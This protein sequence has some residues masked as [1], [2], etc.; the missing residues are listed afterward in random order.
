MDLIGFAEPDASAPAGTAE[1]APA[2]EATAPAIVPSVPA[3]T[4][5]P[6]EGMSGQGAPEASQLRIWE[7]NHERELAQFATKEESDR[8]EKREAAG[9]QLRQWHEDRAEEIKKRHS[10]KRAEEE[11]ASELKTDG[12]KDVGNPWE[13]VVELINTNARTA[14]ECRDTSRMAALLIHLK[15]SP[16]AIAA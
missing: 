3:D 8:K 10:S 13:R 4:S 6:F 9:G 12:A 1:A 5:D 16:V 11:A 14:D 15:N 2:W 7:D